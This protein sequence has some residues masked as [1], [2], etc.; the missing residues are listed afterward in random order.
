MLGIVWL[1]GDAFVCV[2]FFCVGWL[3][4]VVFSWILGCILCSVL[5]VCVCV[6]RGLHV[7]FGRVVI[8]FQCDICLVGKGCRVVCCGWW[9]VH[10]MGFMSV[11]LLFFF[12]LWD[13]VLACGVLVLF[14]PH[15]IVYYRVPGL[16]CVG[17]QTSTR[18]ACLSTVSF[19]LWLR[20]IGTCVIISPRAVDCT[21]VLVRDP[22][23]WPIVRLISCAWR[24]SIR[25]FAA[26]CK[27][28]GSLGYV[29]GGLGALRMFH[30]IGVG[31][32][33]GRLHGLVLPF[34]VRRSVNIFRY[35]WW[36]WC[37]VVSRRFA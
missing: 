1:V 20:T 2:V 3:F 8:C 23:I 26:A 24:S 13:F 33:G 4:G 30:T 25:Q 15:C 17:G 11:M 27:G 10:G 6:E 22:G 37:S 29:F 32:Y 9:W 21:I 31:G 5:V 34:L 28:C 14:H 35:M 16:R 18:L 19:P 12:V 36:V 7:Y